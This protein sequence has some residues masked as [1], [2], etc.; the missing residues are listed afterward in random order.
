LQKERLELHSS[1][2]P[3]DPDDRWE[4]LDLEI[5]GSPEEIEDFRVTDR[6][7]YDAAADELHFPK[8]RGRKTIIAAAI[9]RMAAD[10]GFSNP[11]AVSQEEIAQHPNYAKVLKQFG[12]ELQAVIDGNLAIG[13]RTLA[14]S[15]ATHERLKSEATQQS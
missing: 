11:G 5:Q 3:D 6:A 7:I 14:F 1:F 2:W 9:R 15:L 12:L 8:G 4:D 13:P 10:L